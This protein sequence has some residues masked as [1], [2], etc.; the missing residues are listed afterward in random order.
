MSPQ[1]QGCS[2]P[3]GPLCLAGAGPA[4]LTLPA[5][6]RAVGDSLP[7]NPFLEF[8]GNSNIF[9]GPFLLFTKPTVKFQ[10]VLQP[11]CIS[12][13]LM[14]SANAIRSSCPITQTANGN[15]RGSDPGLT[16]LHSALGDRAAA[17]FH[18]ILLLHFSSLLKISPSCLNIT[19]S[20]HRLVGSCPSRH[21]QGR[22]LPS[23]GRAGPLHHQH[24]GTLST[25]A[26]VNA[27][28]ALPLPDT[29][30]V[31]CPKRRAPKAVMCYSGSSQNNCP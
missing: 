15:R 13:S 16:P 29:C 5:H 19:E 26:E 7:S 28:P 3:P 30:R 14:A 8:P 17:A 31:L 4:Q 1:P 10:P 18:P 22:A 12:P 21:R 6:I 9:V 2:P 23:P 11:S 27:L 25:S 24:G 20:R